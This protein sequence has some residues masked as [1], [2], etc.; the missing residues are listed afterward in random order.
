[1]EFFS[2]TIDAEFLGATL[3][4]P[5]VS[6]GCIGQVSLEILAHTFS[7]PLA[8]YLYDENVLPCA[9]YNPLGAESP[10]I[11][12]S[13]ELYRAPGH[14]LF[15]LQQRSPVIPGRLRFF[16]THLGEWAKAQGFARVFIVGSIDAAIRKDVQILDRGLRFVSTDDDLSSWL[17]AAGLK[18]L[19]EDLFEREEGE[20]RVSPWPLVHRLRVE[21]IVACCVLSF[22][23]EGNNVPNS[24]ALAETLSGLLDLPLEKRDWKL[25]PLLE[26]NLAV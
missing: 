10:K 26:N 24:L 11:A 2:R 6:I 8:G 18:E 19:E 16:A 15:F 12:L 17:V 5:A 9:G 20:R 14:K 22:A 4:V 7:L 3:V 23:S 13:L 1:M 21:G 25:P